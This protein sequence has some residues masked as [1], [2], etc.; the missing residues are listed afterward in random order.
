MKNC[1]NQTYQALM[2]LKTDRRILISGTPIQN[3]L[4]EYFSLINFVNPGMLGSI[5]EFRRLY[6]NPI[7]RGQDAGATDKEAEICEQSIIQLTTL[8]KQC[9][10]RRTN[11]IL[12]KYLP[13]KF[14][15]IICVRMS[16]LQEEL[17]ENYLRSDVVKKSMKESK[18]H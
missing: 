6:E 15:M 12:T 1:E 14:E 17:Y 7:L 4:T 11:T 18:N 16:G 5:N 2:G 10:I 13:M 9:M 3:D 8:V